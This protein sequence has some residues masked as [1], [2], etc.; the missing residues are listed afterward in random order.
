[1][2]NLKMKT[3]TVSANLDSLKPLADY[4]I[5]ASEAANLD[6]KKTYKLRLAV[7]EIATNII[8]HGYEE[9]GKTGNITIS[10]EIDSNGLKITLED[11]AVF[12]DPREKMSAEVETIDQPLEKRNIG[13]LGI[14]LTISGV[15]EFQYKRVDN[16][17]Y[18]I[19]TMCF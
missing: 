17:N 6:K 2:K 18:N 19:F 16:R 11:T 7:D 9:T 15:D 14:Y 10:G 12:F 4:V 5:Q 1:M 8:T 3:L 13:G